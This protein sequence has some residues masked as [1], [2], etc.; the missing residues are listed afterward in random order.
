MENSPFRSQDNL[1]PAPLPD[2]SAAK[3]YASAAQPYPG[4]DAAKRSGNGSGWILA[5]AILQVIGSIIVFAISR[6][7]MEPLAAGIMLAILL[8]LAAI[9]FGL[10][11]WAKKSPFPALL[12]T[13]IIFLSFHLLDAVVEPANLFRG[14]FIKIIFVVGLATALKKA[15]TK[16]REAE[17]EA[18][19]S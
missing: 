7:T 18:A 4:S 3:P 6:N 2:P 16:K 15:Y 11:F 13:L 5:L 14:I 12:T 19:Q 17:L 9:Y 10:W 8:G 1:P